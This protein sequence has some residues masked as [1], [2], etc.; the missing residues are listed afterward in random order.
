MTNPNPQFLGVF[1]LTSLHHCSYFWLGD[2][3]GNDDDDKDDDD[4]G[5]DHHV[6][7][8]DEYDDDE[9][10]GRQVQ[11]LERGGDDDGDDD[12][13]AD[14]RQVQVLEGGSWK[15][16]ALHGLA[17]ITPC[18]SALLQHYP[19]SSSL[20]LKLRPLLICAHSKFFNMAASILCASLAKFTWLRGPKRVSTVCKRT[21]KTLRRGGCNFPPMQSCYKLPSSQLL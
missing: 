4:D 2:G 13:E 5:E 18:S 3:H 6:N 14:G 12:D 17:R 20:A 9:G 10:G 21:F 16:E 15:L 11:V 1:S 19:R 8:E 7:Q